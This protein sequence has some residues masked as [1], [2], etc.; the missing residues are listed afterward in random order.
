MV[1]IVSQFLRLERLRITPELP[2]TA[3]PCRLLHVQ[4]Q[5]E[6][7]LE[8]DPSYFEG[9]INAL[10][11]LGYGALMKDYVLPKELDPFAEVLGEDDDD[12][13]NGAAITL[14]LSTKPSDLRH[15]NLHREVH[16][17]WVDLHPTTKA[18][19]ERF[20]HPKFRLPSRTSGLDA[21]SDLVSRCHKCRISQTHLTGS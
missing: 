21:V 4:D 14:E 2:S 12:P 11:K 18:N 15:Q 20:E 8:I 9:V 16:S 1:S 5:R 19:L 17:K 6:P 7:S 3:W 10:K 13:Y